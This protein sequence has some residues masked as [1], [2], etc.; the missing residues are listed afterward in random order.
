MIH[1]PLNNLSCLVLIVLSISCFCAD[2]TN[3]AQL[4]QIPSE[5]VNALE[6]GQ[7][8]SLHGVVNEQDK[9]WHHDSSLHFF[10]VS[11]I[12]HRT[13]FLS[14]YTIFNMA[15]NRIPPNLDPRL[16]DSSETLSHVEEIQDGVRR[17]NRRA[18]IT[19][20]SHDDND[21]SFSPENCFALVVLTERKNET[22]DKLDTNFTQEEDKE[23]VKNLQRTTF[24]S[25]WTPSSTGRYMETDYLIA[26]KKGHQMTEDEWRE[27]D[28]DLKKLKVAA[29]LDKKDPTSS[30]SMSHHVSVVAAQMEVRRRAKLTAKDIFDAHWDKAK[31]LRDERREYDEVKAKE[32][33]DTKD[34]EKAR[35][36]T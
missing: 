30:L 2:S 16:F 6:T 20:P 14:L 24:G 36:K 32:A 9:M 7:G 5:A 17:S 26:L 34:A 8:P 12:C 25:Y 19:T 23:T 31:R 1:S 11:S 27:T 3:L 21:D 28:R 22:K 33:R 29:K 35:K 4:T 15:R 18:A 10:L 13:L